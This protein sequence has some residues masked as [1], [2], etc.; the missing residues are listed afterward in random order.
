M[1]PRASGNE[2]AG[3]Q[4]P[5]LRSRSI[6]AVLSGSGCKQ[7]RQTQPAAKGARD[8]QERCPCQVSSLTC[9]K[10]QLALIGKVDLN[11]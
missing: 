2:A 6:N 1:T 3:S 4:G 5:R 9:V 10:V 11:L 7:T 8:T